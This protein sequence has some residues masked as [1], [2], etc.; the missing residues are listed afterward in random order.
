MG[1]AILS[2]SFARVCEVRHIIFP[3]YSYD[4]CTANKLVTTA[5]ITSNNVI[6]YRLLYGVQFIIIVFLVRNLYTQN[7]KLDCHKRIA[8]VL[9]KSLNCKLAKWQWI[10]HIRV[11]GRFMSLMCCSLFMK[12]SNALHHLSSELS[13]MPH[14]SQ[15]SVY[16]L[17]HEFCQII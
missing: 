15:E 8:E 10:F 7:I 1:N 14:S 16:Q 3:S 9:V 6:V 11:Y 12:K 4:T 5:L 2:F 13:H 17:K